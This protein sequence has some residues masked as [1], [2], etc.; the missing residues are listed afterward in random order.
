MM[1]WCTLTP[2]GIEVAEFLGKGL[3][4][5]KFDAIYSSDSGRSIET[6]NIILEQSGQKYLNLLTDWSLREFNFG[7]YEGDLT[8]TMWSGIAKAEGKTIEE[9]MKSFTVESFVSQE[10]KR[11][12]KS[13]LLDIVS[14]SLTYYLKNHANSTLYTY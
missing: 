11:G 5:I 6:A 8:H 12:Y 7:T 4:D 10:K 3:T 13:P 1:G 9:W 14:H 2:A